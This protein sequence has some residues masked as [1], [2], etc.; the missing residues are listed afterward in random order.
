MISSPGCVLSKRHFVNTLCE[1][2]GC[3]IYLP[4]W[5]M[6]ITVALGRQMQ[7]KILHG[8]WSCMVVLGNSGDMLVERR[9]KK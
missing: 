7:T 8:Q 9:Q 2:G 1:V 3:M 5:D 6:L 4:N